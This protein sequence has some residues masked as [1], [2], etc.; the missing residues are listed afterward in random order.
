MIP[1]VTALFG[2]MK[3]VTLV[4]IVKSRKI[5]VSVPGLCEPSMPNITIRPA[6]I[7]IRLMMT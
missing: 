6:T 5:A 4:R 1:G 3:P 7:A 2:N